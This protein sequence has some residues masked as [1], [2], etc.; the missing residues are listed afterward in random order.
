VRTVPLEPRA[1][2]AAVGGWRHEQVTAVCAYNDE[3]A[4]AV[5]AGMRRHGL[6]A[7]HDLAV[8]GA[9]DIPAAALTEPPLTTIVADEFVTA[10]YVTDRLVASLA[11][12][13]PPPRPGAD[14]IS[15]VRR[16]SA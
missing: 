10:R 15:V 8:I 2:A 12:K 3:V 16:D 5:L 1:A 7:P 9:D 14:V 4:L 11:G 6:T 13:P